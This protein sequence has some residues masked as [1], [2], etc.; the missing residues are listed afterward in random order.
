MS[1]FK[2]S[3]QFGFSKK[4][5]PAES[6]AGDYDRYGEMGAGGAG[7]LPPGTGVRGQDEAAAG[8]ACGRGSRP[9]G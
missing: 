6:R 3:E 1:L 4:K 8:G 7:Y 9:E 5:H 2:G